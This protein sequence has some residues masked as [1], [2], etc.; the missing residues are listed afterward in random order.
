MREAER[1][2]SLSG[3]HLGTGGSGWAES[4]TLAQDQRFIRIERA[5]S[6]GIEGDRAGADRVAGFGWLQVVLVAAPLAGGQIGADQIGGRG[7][8]EAAGRRHQVQKG[9]SELAVLRLIFRQ[10]GVNGGDRVYRSQFPRDEG[11]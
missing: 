7:L 3:L 8:G 11:I 4:G 5:R 9:G 1:A 2:A 6:R 10:G